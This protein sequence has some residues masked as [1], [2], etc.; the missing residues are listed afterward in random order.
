MDLYRQTQRLA[1][2]QPELRRYLVPMLRRA[3]Q[4]QDGQLLLAPPNPLQE[5]TPLRLSLIPGVDTKMYQL[6]VALYTPFLTEEHLESMFQF[7]I[8]LKDKPIGFLSLGKSNFIQTALAPGYTGQGF[9]AETIRALLQWYPLDSIGWTTHPANIPSMTL[10][11]NLGG[12]LLQ[13]KGD[14]VTG[15]IWSGRAAPG[16]ARNKL[17]TA[18][19]KADASYK[20]WVKEMEGRKEEAAALKSYLEGH[21]LS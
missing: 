21:S 3:A 19:G 16:E 20:K 14:S 10:L 1:N 7:I 12:G 2:L 5:D 13:S 4:S 6:M 18:L 17:D 9:G 8:A 15:R 11:K